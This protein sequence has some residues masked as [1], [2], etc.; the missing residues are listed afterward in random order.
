MNIY[1]VTSTGD[2]YLENGTRI[3]NPSL[4]RKS[5]GNLP[6][7]LYGNAYRINWQNVKSRG[8]GLPSNWEKR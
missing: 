3:V 5:A 2:A 8:M 4:Y 6:I 1:Y 7:F